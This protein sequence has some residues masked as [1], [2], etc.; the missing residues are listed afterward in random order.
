[1]NWKPDKNKQLP[2]YKQI[3][4]FLESKILNGEYPPGS[5]LPSERE[6]A[7]LFKVNRSTVKIAYEELQSTGLVNRMV[8]L[9]TVVN[10]AI[11]G[12]Q[13]K[14]LP[15]WEKYIKEGHH[16]MN[17]PLNQ[18]IFHYIRSNDSTI[19]FAIGELC[20][21]L[22]P[23]KPLN[24]ISFNMGDY[25]G[26]EHVQGNLALREAIS[27]HM[28]E[29]QNIKSTASSILITSGAQQAVHLI[30]RCLLK[31]GDSV[32]IEDPSYAYSMPIFHSKELNTCLL[33]VG[34]EG[35]D[36]EDIINLYKKHQIKMIIISPNYQNPTGVT[37]SLQ[38]RKEI[39]N[40]C[41]KYGIAIVEQDPYSTLGYTNGTNSALKSMDTEGV[42]LYVNS[43]SNMVASGLR[44]GWI[45]GPQSVINLLTDVKQ[46][47]D[48]GQSTILQLMATK[49]LDSE[50]FNQHIENLKKGLKEKRDLT[51]QALKRELKEDIQFSIPEGGIHLW[52]TIN[53]KIDESF[54]FKES[55]KN[56][57]VFA[58]GTTLGS[59]SNHLL[60]T[61]GSV[62]T[63]LIEDGIQRFVQAYKKCRK[64]L[65]KAL[66]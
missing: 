20:K 35:I 54:L 19:N 6:L 21:D 8:G 32:A 9:G 56:G 34:K 11:W 46:Q 10:E 26:Y 5:R 58:P 1:M 51:I 36:P 42:V 28:K 41:T 38:R 57:V 60:I 55:I 22:I 64:S 2:L 33:P 3:F 16:Q 15:N 50:L 30:I 31:P 61:Y 47:I 43:L 44:I 45:L 40:I 59:K 29:F 53:D 13:K 23:M 18:Q 52:C 27:S 66:F 25:L 62:N 49:L 63:N 4:L 39:L 37:L 24:E 17:N 12:N 14:R 65:P 48:F 7:N